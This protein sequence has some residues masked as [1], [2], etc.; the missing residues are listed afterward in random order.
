[1]SWRWAL[2]ILLLGACTVNPAERNQA[3]NAL[4]RVGRYD[5]ALLAYQLAQVNASDEAIF[6]FNAGVNQLAAQEWLSAEAAFSQAL[7]FADPQMQ[8]LIYYGLGEAYFRQADY[9]RAL[10]AYRQVL[11]LDPTNEDARY[12]YELALRRLPTPTPNVSP[13]PTT[14]DE[15]AENP[16]TPT[17]TPTP[18]PESEQNP[19]PETTPTA[20]P[21]PDGDSNSEDPAEPPPTVPP[22]MSEE[23]ALDL[24]NDIQQGQGILMRPNSGGTAAQD[25]VPTERDW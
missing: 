2:L 9:V 14:T 22:L 24:L 5:E 16:T 23:T 8:A 18:S 7:R 19:T 21:P 17:Q 25:G 4:L 15:S 3:G 10:N 1:M 13:T 11:V 12:N 6:Y 20:Q